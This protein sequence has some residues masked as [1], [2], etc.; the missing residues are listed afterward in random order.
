MGYGGLTISVDTDERL[1]VSH[2]MLCIEYDR[3]QFLLLC[4]K[5]DTSI[6]NF[7][8]EFDFLMNTIEVFYEII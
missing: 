3:F 6:T 4:L 7:R 8:S 5:I 2:I 1:W